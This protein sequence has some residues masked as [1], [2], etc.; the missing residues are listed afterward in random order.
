VINCDRF[1]CWFHGETHSEKGPPI[2][3]A[4]MCE[5]CLPLVTDGKL[6]YDPDDY[7]VG[8]A[9][10]GAAAPASADPPLQQPA[11]AH[12]HAAPAAATG[13]AHPL[14]HIP[15][16]TSHRLGYNR[17]IAF[18]WRCGSWTSGEHPRAIVNRCNEAPTS[19]A[20][21][22]ALA[23]LRKGLTPKPRQQWPLPP[24]VGPPPGYIIMS[25]PPADAP[26]RQ[27]ARSKAFRK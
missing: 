18:C 12:A 5:P 19:G 27:S 17:G 1:A 16:H 15:F 10:S 25:E 21:H 26:R 4:W 11:P 9:A 6:P 22:D 8:N 20:G 13:A 3:T 23:R 14:G 24:E 2:S 7:K